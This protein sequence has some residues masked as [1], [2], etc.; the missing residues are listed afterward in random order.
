MGVVRA[1]TRTVD[2][3]GP[4]VRVAARVAHRRTHAAGDGGTAVLVATDTTPLDP[5]VVAQ[6]ERLRRLRDR[7]L[8]SA[9]E[10]EALSAR[11]AHP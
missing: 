9:D 5:Y 7:G 8:L 4:A 1:M 3:T 10:L 2:D 6:L 11:L